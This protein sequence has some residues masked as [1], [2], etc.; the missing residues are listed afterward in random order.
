MGTVL[1]IHG[2]RGLVN[3]LGALGIIPGAKITKISSMSSRGPT[4]VLVNRT[5]VALGFGMA[6][7]II[8]SVDRT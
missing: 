8:I 4:T 6:S 2:G 5:H 3:R 7:K 1:R